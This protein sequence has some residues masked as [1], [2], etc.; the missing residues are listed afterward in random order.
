MQWLILT[1]REGYSMDPWTF[2]RVTTFIHAPRREKPIDA[3]QTPYWLPAYFWTWK[4]ADWPR[5]LVG[6]CQCSYWFWTNQRQLDK[7][8]CKGGKVH[9]ALWWAY[10]HSAVVSLRALCSVVSLRAV[11]WWAYVHFALWWAY[12]HFAVVSLHALSRTRVVCILLML[13]NLLFDEQGDDWSPWW[14]RQ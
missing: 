3:L 12:V 7:Q 13:L 1:T 8:Q 11:L 10:V 9:S 2:K 4:D 5:Q 6:S 14:W